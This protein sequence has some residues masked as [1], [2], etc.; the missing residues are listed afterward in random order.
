MVE[1]ADLDGI[2]GEVGESDG[3]HG[4]GCAERD[5]CR[6]LIEVVAAESHRSE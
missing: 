6:G 5:Q 1:E 4:R 3:F 2:V